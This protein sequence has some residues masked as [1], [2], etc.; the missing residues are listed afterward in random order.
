M[1]TTFINGSSME[2]SPRSIARM[3]GLFWLITFVMGA[4]ALSIYDGFVVAGDAAATASNLLSRES[5]YRLGVSANLVATMAYLVATLF[6]YELLRPVSKRISLL[7]AFFSLTACAISCVAHALQLAPLAI[8]RGE[9]HAA[10]FT[11]EQVD[12]LAR[13]F[14]Q[15]SEQT[16]SVAFAFFG[17]HVF[18]IGVLILRS[19]FLHRAVGLLMLFGGLG[20]LTFAFANLLSPE[21]GRTLSPYILFPGILGEGALVVWLLVK[22]VNTNRWME[23]AAGV[24]EAVGARVPELP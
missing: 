14:L 3:G 15:T 18:L 17:L 19:T 1:T 16:A 23:Q 12:G 24:Q 6:V 5:F 2:M 10:L 9:S 8:L 21:L 13:L 7:A 20:W 4:L 11:R 22:G